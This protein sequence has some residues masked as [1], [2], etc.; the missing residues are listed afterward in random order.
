M[1]AKQEKIVLTRRRLLQ[2]AGVLGAAAG[3]HTLTATYDVVA[4]APDISKPAMRS[5]H[6]VMASAGATLPALPPLEV[7]ALNRMGF[8]PGVGDLSAF[9]NLG[10]TDE[11]RLTA[12]VDQQLTP[13]SIDDSACDAIIAGH[14]FST[15][16]KSLA[17]LWADHVMVENLTWDER[18]QPVR[19]TEHAAFLRA[20]YSKRQLQEVLADFWHNH[21]NVFGW[22]SWSAPVWVHYDRDV[23]RGNMLGNF[24]Q[25][26]VAVAQSPAMLYYLDNQSN[27]GGNPNENYARELFELHCLGA[28]NYLGVVPLQISESGQFEHPAPKDANGRP[29]LYV[30]ADVYGATTCFTGWRINRDTGA[31]EFDASAHF[32]YQKLVL[33]QA[34]PDSQGI[35]DGYDVLKLL[36]EHSGTARYVSRKLCRRLVSD[37]PSESLVQAAADV[38]L[39]HKDASD[40]LK[41]VVRAILLSDEFK[42]TWAEK[43]KRPLEF[44]ASLL[45][46][47]SADFSLDDHFIWR[48]N[49]TGQPI[50]QWRPPDGFPDLH[51]DW[52]S[53]MPMLQRWRLAF[54][55]LEWK[56]DDPD[57]IDAYR[58]RFG[59]P[60]QYKTPY[61]IVDYW[62]YVLLGRALPDVERWPIV[63]FMAYGRQPASDL[64]ADQIEE[65]LRYMI[66]LIL[67]SPSFQWR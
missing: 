13:E 46:A 21:F 32:P 59:H 51:E 3:A 4:Q 48:Y 60:V 57:K 2:G 9:R 1:S 49:R 40:Q 12:Y 31:F 42:N 8:G 5:S 62:S 50:F 10:S 44:C 55:L 34:I 27:S 25:M 47:T 19:E 20:V 56:Y 16:N 17:Q 54:W 66:A 58:I 67:V 52:T 26:L 28:E 64:P 37:T 7:I 43:V 15:L 24:Y 22:D 39:A 6:T 30:D 14:G 63:E 18:T 11:E 61:D 65:R 35:K 29:L 53:T 41:H 33:A 23:I 45:R 36:A 38:F